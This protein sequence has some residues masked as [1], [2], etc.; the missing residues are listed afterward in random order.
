MLAL[1]NEN[2]DRGSFFLVEKYFTLFMQK[3]CSNTLLNRITSSNEEAI[4]H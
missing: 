2:L 3:V 1:G 4:S